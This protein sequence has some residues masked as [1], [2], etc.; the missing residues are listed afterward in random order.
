MGMV[1]A[2]N[3]PWIVFMV[4]F[5]GDVRPG[6]GYSFLCLVLTFAGELL[7]CLLATCQLLDDGF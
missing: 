6:L 1:D 3:G 2:E 7:A 5:F 4:C